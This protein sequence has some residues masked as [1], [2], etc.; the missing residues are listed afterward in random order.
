M[1]NDGRID[2]QEFTILQ[3][4]HSGVLSKLVNVDCKMEAKNRTQSQKSSLN[5]IDSLKKAIK[6]RSMPHHVCTLPLCCLVC[7]HSTN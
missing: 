5:K 4:F 6:G 7:Y 3:M 1:L 2:K